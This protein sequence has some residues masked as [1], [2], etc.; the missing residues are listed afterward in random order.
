MKLE[1]SDEDVK[2]EMVAMVVMVE[3]VMR[4]VGEEGEMRKKAT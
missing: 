3:R 1:S 4:V 2:R